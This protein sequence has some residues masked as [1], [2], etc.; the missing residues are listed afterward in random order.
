MWPTLSSAECVLRAGIDSV[1]LWQKSLFYFVAKCE[2][3]PVR[4]GMTT[5][6]LD[7]S[8]TEASACFMVN[9]MKRMWELRKSINVVAQCSGVFNQFSLVFELGWL[10]GCLVATLCPIWF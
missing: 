6:V 4:S 1:S 2:E 10:I 7:C 9:Q 8:V 5:R 3:R